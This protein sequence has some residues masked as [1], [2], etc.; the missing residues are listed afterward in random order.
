MELVVCQGAREENVHL[1][2][3]PAG[4]RIKVGDATYEVD[5]VAAGPSV[6]SLIIEGRQYE[7]AVRSRGEGRYEIEAADGAWTVELMDPLTH[8]AQQSH[9]GDRKSRAHQVTA[10]MPGRVVKLLVS[11]GDEVSTGQGL[12][13]LEAMKMENEIQA[14]SAGVIKKVLVEE[15]QAVDGGDPMFEII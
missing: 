12:V 7:V 13:V 10:Y 8:L 6:K 15:G 14:E 1:E 5:A 11:E 4:Y 3:T 9:G 2:R